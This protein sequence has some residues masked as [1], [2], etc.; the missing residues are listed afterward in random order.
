MD[1]K[2]SKDIYPFAGKFLELNGFKLHYLDEG[3]GEPVVMLHGNPSWSIYYRNMVNGLK[4]NYRCIVPDHIGCGLS[5]KPDES[6]YNYVL[7]QRVEDLESLLNHLKIDKN[8]TLIVHDWGGMIGMSY[9][10]LHPEAIK[11]IVILNTGAFHQPRKNEL[12]FSLW[13]SRDTQIGALMILG[14]NAF[15]RGAANLCCTRKKMSKEL[16]DAYCAPYNSWKNRIATLRF[17]QDI[18]L[19]KGEPSYDFITEVQN[20]LTLFRNTPV[21]ICWGEKDFVFN[22]YFLEEWQKYLPNAV[23]HRF[24]DC[25]HYVLEDASDEIIKLVDEFLNAHPLKI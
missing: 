22:N 5:D 7:S 16:R 9:A 21:L 12:P 15:S 10:T 25:G 23:V 19:K 18:P 14:F 20:K 1:L 13:L 17:V 8:I 3:E 6:E 4:D 24:P 11:R 2:I